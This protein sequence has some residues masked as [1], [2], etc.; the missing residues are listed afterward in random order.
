MFRT[1]EVNLHSSTAW[2]SAGSTLKFRW[3]IRRDHDLGSG[4]STSSTSAA[5][6][7]DGGRIVL[8]GTISR[9]PET[10]RRAPRKKVVRL[11]DYNSS[12]ADARRTC[13]CA[14]AGGSMAAANAGRELL[15][16]SACGRAIT[17][18]SNLG[19]EQ[20]RVAWRAH[21]SQPLV[22][23]ADE[24]RQSRQRERQH[25]LDLLLELNRRKARR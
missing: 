18:R 17:I 23:M 8:D 10:T 19:G 13:C 24:P 1:E 6:H 25:V 3:P 4:K 15:A 12:H 14:R 2:T 21:S 7:T 5:R 11:S 16:R 22:L 20:Q 9:L